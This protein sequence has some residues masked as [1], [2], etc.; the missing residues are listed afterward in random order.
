M[1]TKSRIL[2]A[3]FGDVG[4][5]SDLTTLQSAI[6]TMPGMVVTLRDDSSYNIIN[7]EPTSSVA[8]LVLLVFLNE[9]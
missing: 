6:G 1:H 3:L 7:T 5:I 2:L 8:I 4:I 9:L